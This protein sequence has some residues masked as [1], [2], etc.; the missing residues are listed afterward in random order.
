M[1]KMVK[2]FCFSISKTEACFLHPWFF[3]WNINNWLLYIQNR[4]M[5]ME[6]LPNLL[7]LS[8]FYLFKRRCALFWLS[9]KIFCSAPVAN[10]TLIIGCFT[11]Q[12]RRI[13]CLVKFSVK[14]V[15]HL[16]EDDSTAWVASDAIP[17][18]L[19]LNA[20][21]QFLHVSFYHLRCTDDQEMGKAGVRGGKILTSKNLTIS[22][23]N[24]SNRH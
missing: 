20:L 21:W 3:N 22:S 6:I 12:R 11:P 14:F 17:E 13:L 24:S 18:L 16:L 9:D 1:W 23:S 19:Q 5:T 2:C 7:V 15:K 4:N 10:K 8:L